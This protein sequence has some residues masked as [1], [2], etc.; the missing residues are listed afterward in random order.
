MPLS[1]AECGGGSGGGGGGGLPLIGCFPAEDVSDEVG[2]EVDD[3]SDSNE[4]DPV[5]EEVEDVEKEAPVW[6]VVAAR[7]G[8]EESGGLLRNV[9]EAVDVEE[10]ISVAPSFVF[11]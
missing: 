2:K 11:S 6:T 10:P 7:D 9:V 8:L 1:I 4:V 5:Y 3:D